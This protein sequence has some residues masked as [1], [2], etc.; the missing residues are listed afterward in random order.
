MNKEI[1]VD[2]K[3]CMNL[4]S[5]VLEIIFCFTKYSKVHE[6][7]ITLVNSKREEYSSC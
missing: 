4:Y 3:Q 5:L 1:I 2:F 7:I 6:N